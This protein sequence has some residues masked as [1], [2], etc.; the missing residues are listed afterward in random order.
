MTMMPQ[1]LMNS[2]S[3]RATSLKSPKKVRDTP[4]PVGLCN[5]VENYKSSSFSESSQK[6]FSAAVY[7]TVRVPNKASVP[8]WHTFPLFFWAINS[9]LYI[10]LVNMNSRGQPEILRGISLYQ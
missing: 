8:H 4:H 2:L 6:V 10:Y 3:K 9:I 5:S 7:T 1:T